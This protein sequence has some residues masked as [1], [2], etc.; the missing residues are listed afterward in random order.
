MAHASVNE[1]ARDEAWT[2]RPERSFCRA[3]YSMNAARAAP[4]T[5]ERSWS[6]TFGSVAAHRSQWSGV[7]VLRSRLHDSALPDRLHF[8]SVVNGSAR[9]TRS[10]PPTTRSEYASSRHGTCSSRQAIP[11]TAG[12]ADSL[13]ASRSCQAGRPSLFNVRRSDRVIAMFGFAA[14]A[15]PSRRI[16]SLLSST[17]NWRKPRGSEGDSA[18]G[19]RVHLGR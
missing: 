4:D 11:G 19:W 18:R 9:W 5:A 13:M 17:S 10:T 1:S 2:R 12:A 7:A 16:Q 3:G 8:H 15:R 14:R 6:R